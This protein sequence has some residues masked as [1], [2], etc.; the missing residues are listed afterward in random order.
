MEGERGI[1]GRARKESISMALAIKILRGRQNAY[2]DELPERRLLFFAA[3]ASHLARPV[4][5]IR[6]QLDAGRALAEIARAH[7]KD[8]DA[9][10]ARLVAA[11]LCSHTAGLSSMILNQLVEQLVDLPLVPQPPDL[12]E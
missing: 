10:K 1:K 12:A 9:L 3:A 7:G 5:E 11:L 2:L 4:S 8:V 6:A